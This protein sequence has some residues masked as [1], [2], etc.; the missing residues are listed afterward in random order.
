MIKRSCFLSI[1]LLAT[2]IVARTPK[3]ENTQ[4]PNINESEII[5]LLCDEIINKYDSKKIEEYEQKI[6]KSLVSYIKRCVEHKKNIPNIQNV[7]R[8]IKNFLEYLSSESDFDSAYAAASMIFMTTW[9]DVINKF[10]LV[11]K[12]ETEKRNLQLTSQEITK[13]VEKVFLNKIT[14]RLQELE[15]NMKN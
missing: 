1:L 9:S 4:A 12:D 8:T 15:N 3:I 13:L 14:K 7:E 5:Q 10:A 6:Q 11:V 2:S